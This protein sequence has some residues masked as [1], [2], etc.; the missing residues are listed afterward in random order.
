VS[1]RGGWIAEALHD[2][3]P[4]GRTALV[5]G[6]ARTLLLAG[7][8]VGIGTVLRSA[9]A[10]GPLVGPVLATALLVLLG[11]LAG[12]RAEGLVGRMRAATESRWRTR[13]LAPALAR[14]GTAPSGSDGEILDAA[15]TGVEKIAE[16]RAGFLMPTLAAFTSPLLVLGVWA[17]AIG[18]GNA[19]VL[20]VFVAAV[21][22]L[23]LLG[24]RALRRSN[25]RFRREQARAGAAYLEL[26]EG[27]GT[28]AV[29][30][31]AARVLEDYARSARGTMRTL[32]RLLARNQVVIVVHDAVFGLLM[33]CLAIGLVLHGAL[34]GSLDLGAALSGILL[35]VLLQ[36]PMGRIGRTFYVALGGRARR[37]QL[38]DMLG[39]HSVG[40][41][42]R[43]E[44]EARGVGFTSGSG[45]ADLSP[46]PVPHLAAPAVPAPAVPA[47][48]ALELRG[49][50][51]QRGDRTV[52]AD[53]SLR[54]PA[55]ARVALV[56][57][58]GAGKTS[59]LRILAG[60][61]EPGDG[62]VLVDGRPSTAA[63]RRALTATL[64][65]RVELASTT[66][67]DNLRLVA[68]DADD[69]TLEDALRSAGLAQEVGSWPDG[70]RT[71]VGL[72]GALLSGGQRRRLGLARVLVQQRP[73]VILDEPTADLDS[74]SER[75]VRAALAAVHAGRTVIETTHRLHAALG[76]D[77]M[78]VLEDGAVREIGTPHELE[79]RS[80]YA[81]R[82]L[83]AEAGD[84]A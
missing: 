83:A 28:L 69:R 15:T 79:A 71:R 17:A 27:L 43:A 80:G 34:E 44:S 70:D 1:A 23:I 54:I 10:G 38:E 51:V 35:T 9:Q 33:G 72:G 12:S 78:I 31:A 20:L 47:P 55:G 2:P 14:E 84:R 46:V 41:G 40:P 59:L 11:A 25:G 63:Q 13:V 3:P 4:G 81:A 36:E 65:Q 29:L 58:S 50:R 8:A 75:A 18:P 73:V 62:T 7:A 16:Y 68:P 48:P 61:E 66:I 37:D 76:S 39:E 22:G 56:G 77:L 6:W 42:T 74:A 32:T 21:P 64:T 45:S 26:V 5:L 82:A 30:G 19:L 57:P 53:V 67:A 52:L 60:L 49:V 24:D